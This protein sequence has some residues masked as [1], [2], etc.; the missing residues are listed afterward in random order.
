MLF[1]VWHGPVVG[2]GGRSVGG[3]WYQGGCTRVGIPGWLYRGTTQPAARGANPTSEAG[4]GTP[5]GVEWVGG[6]QRAYLGRWAGR[7][8]PHPAGPV[9]P[10]GPSLGNTL[11]NAHLRPKGRELTSFPRNL[12]KTSGC[13][14]N[15]SIRP[16]IVPISK[17][18]PKSQL[19]IFWDFH[20]R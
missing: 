15:M 19:L 17:T 10:Y 1:S 9:G 5:A 4:P 18:G 6:V 3:V 16:V 11:R 12:V 13:H 2:A 20:N 8:F 7:A 14:Q